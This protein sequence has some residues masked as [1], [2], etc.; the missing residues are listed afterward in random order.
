MPKQPLGN[1]LDYIRQMAGAPA[2]QGLTDQELLRTYAMD[3]DEAAFALL[4]RR[5]GPM[6]WGVCQRVLQHTQDAED[7][8]QATFLVLASKADRILWQADVSNWLYA[9][10]WR[11]ARKA[12]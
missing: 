6:V 9:V 5:H 1:V 4:V 2:G 7:A 10:A 12:K 8:F 11:V 3:R